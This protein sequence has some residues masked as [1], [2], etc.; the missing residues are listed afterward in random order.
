MFNVYQQGIITESPVW[1]RFSKFGSSDLSLC[2]EPRLE[3]SSDLDQDALRELMEFNLRK[4]TQELAIDLNTP[5]LEKY[6]K[7]KHEN[8]QRK[9]CTR[10]KKKRCASQ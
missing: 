9:H 4:S 2:N 3:R 7:S 5:P 10:Q 1:K 8:F 6:R